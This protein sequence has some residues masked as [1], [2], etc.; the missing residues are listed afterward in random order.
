[1][2]ERAAAT[3]EEVRTLVDRSTDLLSRIDE[4][5]APPAPQGR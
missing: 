4:L 3:A 1:V 2:A 5:C